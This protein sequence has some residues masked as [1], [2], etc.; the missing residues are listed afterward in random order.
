[1]I[2]CELDKIFESKWK[3]HVKVKWYAVGPQDEGFVLKSG[4]R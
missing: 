4:V 2:I 1:M 3:S